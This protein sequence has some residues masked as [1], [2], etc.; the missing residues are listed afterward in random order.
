MLANTIY[1]TIKNILLQ[2]KS[3]LVKS[4]NTTMVYAYFEI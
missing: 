1:T 4:I 3:Q 2:A